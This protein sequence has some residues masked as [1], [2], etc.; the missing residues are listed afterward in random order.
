MKETF[1]KGICPRCKKV[2]V[3]FYTKLFGFKP[4]CRCSKCGNVWEVKK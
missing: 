3:I 4:A 1:V 2:R